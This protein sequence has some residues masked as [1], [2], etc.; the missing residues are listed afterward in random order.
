MLQR[1]RRNHTREAYLELIQHIRNKVPG[2]AL[3]SD[4]ICGFCDETEEEFN[5]TIS[6]IE[7]VE[8][9]MAFLFAYSMR[10][11][12]HAHRRMEDNVP[13]A[14]KKERLIKM[15]D[16][17]KKHQL[18]K[19]KA[20]IGKYHLVMVDGN[21]RLGET[22]LTGLTDTNKRA[23]FQQ[24]ESRQIAVGDLVVAKVIDASQNTLFCETD[25]KKLSVTDFHAAYRTS[26]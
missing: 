15:I 6:L 16:T 4:F 21:G 9:D 12:T 7:K 24:I 20:E 18:I 19:Q 23:V 14:V 17:F 10:E 3:S 13:E 26:V 8:Y 25:G 5:D 2:V 11:K 1:M 22:Q